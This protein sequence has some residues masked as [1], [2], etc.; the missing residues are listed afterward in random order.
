MS[1]H[2]RPRPEETEG[3]VG[4]PRQDHPTVPRATVSIHERLTWGLK[5]I[6]A[7]T[8]LSSRHL[9]RELAAGKMPKPDLRIGRR[10]LWRPETIRRWIGE[11]GR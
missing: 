7:L 2:E 10:V 3:V 6:S 8:G 11:G 1:K 4:D 5:E 9:Q